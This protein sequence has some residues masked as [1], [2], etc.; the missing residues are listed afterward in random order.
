MTTSDTQPLRTAP[1]TG[2]VPF[3][4][5]LTRSVVSAGRRRLAARARARAAE[6]FARRHPQWHASLFDGELLASLPVDRCRRRPEQLAAIWTA[7]FTYP[8][9]AR[10]IADVR[11]LRPVAHTLLQYLE[12]EEEALSLSP[13]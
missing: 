5:A 6:R 7:Q 12:E 8:D 4:I 1:S 13:R 3:T 2:T 10:R 9:E 11:A